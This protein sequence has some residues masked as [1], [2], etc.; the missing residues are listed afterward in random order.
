M[1]RLLLIL[2]FTVASCRDRAG[3]FH[4]ALV[5][6]ALS[7]AM[8]QGAGAVVSLDSLGPQN[9]TQFYVFGPYT[10]R[11]GM[12]R[13]LATSQFED[14]GLVSREDIYALFFRR[15]GE[16]WGM[17]LPRS[18]VVF[19]ADVLGREYLRGNASFIVRR[20]PSGERRELANSGAPARG[21]V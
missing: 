15:S 17:T 10:S 2:A 6:S 16:V 1:S 7:G 5:A 14:Y 3:S 21:C 18:R 20:E 12:R 8:E 19:A 4:P 9:W 13:C 11:D